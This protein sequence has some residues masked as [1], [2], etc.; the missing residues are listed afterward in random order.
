MEYIQTL[1]RFEREFFRVTISGVKRILGG[2][3][4]EVIVTIREMTFYQLGFYLTCILAFFV[5]VLPWLQ[6]NIL[7]MSE[8]TIDVGSSAKLGFLLPSILGLIFATVPVPYRLNIYRGVAGL[9]GLIYIAG[10][11][12][13]NPI[14]TSIQS[15]DYHFR[16]WTY[17]YFPILMVQVA[18]SGPALADSAL[19]LTRFQDRL[20]PATRT[21]EASKPTS[22]KRSV[23]PARV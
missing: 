9:A 21:E 22:R 8:E 18:L 16:F 4:G 10:L 2:A 6:Y 19:H 20:F 7:F 3:I 17:V 11:I 1:L 12:F 15:G 23:R 5:A 13:A 14:H